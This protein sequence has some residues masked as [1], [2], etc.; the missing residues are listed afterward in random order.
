MEQ[1]EKYRLNVLTRKLC[2]N[3]TREKIV[4]IAKQNGWEIWRSGREPLKASRQGH[5]SVSIS[6]HNNGAVIPYDT[7]FRIIKLLLEPSFNQEV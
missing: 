4:Q 1:Q 3:I 2:R 5:S 7:A 6:G